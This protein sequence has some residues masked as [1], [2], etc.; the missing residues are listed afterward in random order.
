MK[1]SEINAAIRAMLALA[2][3]MGFALP[4]FAHWSPEQWQDKGPEYDEI[5]AARLGWDVTDFGKGDFAHFGLTLLTIRNGLPDR[6]E[7]KQYCEKLMLAGEGQITPM[8]FHWKKTEDIINRGGGRLVC[9]VY[10]ATDDDRLAETPVTVSI[11]GR[12]LEVPAGTELVLEPGES[13][14]LTPRLYHAFWARPGDGAVLLGEVSTVNDDTHDNRFFEQLPRYP[15]IEEDQPPF[16]LLCHE[17]PP[18]G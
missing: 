2:E 16:R 11:D 10:N 15:G 12:R 5:R 8:H 9:Q 17:Y 13:I 4:P 7:T 18:A 1:R 6:P 14:T 3:K